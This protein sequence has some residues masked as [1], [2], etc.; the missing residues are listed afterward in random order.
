ME[1]PRFVSQFA[2]FVGA[3]DSE[4]MWII[5]GVAACTAP[6]AAAWKQETHY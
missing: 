6:M 1:T 2:T 4:Y 3:D 5:Y